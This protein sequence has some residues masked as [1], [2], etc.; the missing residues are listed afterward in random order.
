MLETIL[1]KQEKLIFKL[2]HLVFLEIQHYMILEMHLQRK[3]KKG[4]VEF[5]KDLFSRNKQM[6]KGQYKP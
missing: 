4:V 3:N 1:I 2:R 5:V 6:I